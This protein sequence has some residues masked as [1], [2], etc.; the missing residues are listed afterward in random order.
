MSNFDDAFAGLMGNEGKYSND[1]RDPGGET[2]YGVTL[3][4]ARAEG[5]TGH[6]IDLPIEEAKRIAKKRYWDPMHCDEMDARLAFQV[7]DAYYNGGNPVKWIQ[8]AVGS[9][10]D[11]VWGPDTANKLKLYDPLKV[12]MKFNAYRLKYLTS[13]TVWS[14]FGKGWANRIANNLL[15]GGE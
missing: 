3:R 12:M 15:K 8:Q 2:M 5:Y 7:F 11:G 10:P 6:M 9:N 13:L 14:S 1:P 4:V